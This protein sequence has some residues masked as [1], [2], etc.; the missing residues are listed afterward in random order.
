M[1]QNRYEQKCCNATKVLRTVL[2]HYGVFVRGVN[3]QTFY[4]CY[5]HFIIIVKIYLDGIIFSELVGLS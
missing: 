3:G 2:S 1:R 5:R 4:C